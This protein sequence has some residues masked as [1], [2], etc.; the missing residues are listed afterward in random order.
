MLTSVVSTS[1][2]FTQ[3]LTVLEASIGLTQLAAVYF[4]IVSGIRNIRNNYAKCKQCKRFI[5]GIDKITLMNSHKSVLQP[6]TVCIARS[7]VE[8]ESNAS[9]WF[10]IIVGIWEI[11]FG[12]SFFF[13]FMNS[14]HL[15]TSSWPK[16][17]FDALI[18]MEIGL[19][20]ILGVMFHAIVVK[21]HKRKV[22]RKCINELRSFD[23]KNGSIH[24]FITSSR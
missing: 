17:V 19:V 15:H 16:P 20:Y 9:F 3:L 10:G 14:Y 6:E 4:N 2:S 23:N 24:S 18:A 8:K 13:L 5:S 1:T 7:V 21:I 11:I 22:I 12:I